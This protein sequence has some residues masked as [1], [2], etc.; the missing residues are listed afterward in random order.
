M[1]KKKWGRAEYQEWCRKLGLRNV[2]NGHL[3]RLHKIAAPLG[4][5]VQGRINAENNHIQTIQKVGARLGGLVT[6]PR[7]ENLKHLDEIRTPEG[8]RRG[9]QITC[10]RRYHGGR[11][12]PKCEICLEELAA[13]NSRINAHHPD[14]NDPL[15]G[16]QIRQLD[17]KPLQS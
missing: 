11:F 5:K 2:R 16:R 14:E 12:N 13:W 6:G 9:G 3:K 7:P 10:H 8:C 15:R 4:G 17:I 1:P